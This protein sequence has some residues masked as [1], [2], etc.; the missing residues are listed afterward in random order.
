VLLDIDQNARESHPIADLP[1]GWEQ[2]RVWEAETVVAGHLRNSFAFF[3]LS[4][5]PVHLHA[6]WA[7]LGISTGRHIARDLR[8]HHQLAPSDQV[9]IVLPEHGSAVYRVQ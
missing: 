1:T 2:V 7:E 8:N 6:R 5:T 9:E 3:N 4:D